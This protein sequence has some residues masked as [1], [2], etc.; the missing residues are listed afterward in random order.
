MSDV[1]HDYDLH[2]AAT[3]EL[4]IQV[5]RART[6]LE[7][8][9]AHLAATEPRSF[10][11]P[12]DV[13][14]VEHVQK[15]AQLLFEAG[16]VSQPVLPIPAG[17][18]VFI[19]YSQEDADLARLISEKL[20]EIGVSNFKADRDIQP[21]SDWAESIWEAIRRCSVFLIVLTPKFLKSQWRLLEG[22]AA[23]ASKKPVLTI[24]H[25]VHQKQVD[26]LFSRW[27]PIQVGPDNDLNP[28]LKA[29]ITLLKAPKQD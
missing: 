12:K 13:V 10:D 2:F 29:I 22:G 3:E 4:D 5:A 1:P 27:Q 25:G 28:V 11:E 14:Q 18:E 21:A 9:A 15:A 24:L 16:K 17:A 8:L 23:L 26:Q 20:T 19:S 7:R 6:I